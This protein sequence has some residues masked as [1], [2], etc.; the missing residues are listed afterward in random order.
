MNWNV[1]NRCSHF[2]LPAV[3]SPLS[4]ARRKNHLPFS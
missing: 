1:E 3:V 2:Q 4:L